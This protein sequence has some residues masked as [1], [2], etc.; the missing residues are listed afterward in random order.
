MLMISENCMRKLDNRGENK[1]LQFICNFAEFT[2]LSYT[3]ERRGR[4][5]SSKECQTGPFAGS[6]T[7]HLLSTLLLSHLLSCISIL[8]GK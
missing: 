5:S 2:I 3:I 1:P 7:E 8:A 4:S 6:A